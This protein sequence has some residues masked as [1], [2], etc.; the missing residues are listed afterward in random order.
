M[1]RSWK[2]AELTSPVRTVLFWEMSGGTA[3]VTDPNEAN[4][5][6]YN[7]WHY[8]GGYPAS[9]FLDL[10]WG[11]PWASTPVDGRHLFGANYVAT[12][13]HAI[14]LLPRGIRGVSAGETAGSTTAVGGGP[15]N[16]EGT[17]YGGTN[18]HELTMSPK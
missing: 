4:S 2:Q 6:G 16:S 9:G 17:L 10:M 15:F 7:G 3:N 8:P 14:W 5:C 1:G 13:G 11:G 18:R 12:D